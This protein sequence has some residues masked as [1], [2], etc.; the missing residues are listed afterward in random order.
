MIIAQRSDQCSAMVHPYPCMHHDNFG[1]FR[2]T[3]KGNDPMACKIIVP[4][5]PPFAPAAQTRVP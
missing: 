4:L 3:E 2:N 5:L 1:M